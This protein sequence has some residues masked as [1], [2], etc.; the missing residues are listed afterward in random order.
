M[1]IF[2]NGKEKL[3]IPETV[4]ASVPRQ[5]LWVTR[6]DCQPPEDV[7]AATN[8]HRRSLLLSEIRATPP[9]GQDV[10]AR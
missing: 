1:S 3:D 8:R 7:T 4:C 5:A 10:H 9:T 6:G 2:R